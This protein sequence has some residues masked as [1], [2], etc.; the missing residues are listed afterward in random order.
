MVGGA[1]A[2][3]LVGIAIFLLIRRKQRTH[4]T[5]KDSEAPTSKVHLQNWA[6][7]LMQHIAC[8]VMYRLHSWMQHV[9]SGYHA[10]IMQTTWTIAAELQASDGTSMGGWASSKNAWQISGAGTSSGG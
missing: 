10:L 8:E 4:A 6:N 9:R 2:L 3:A 7:L 1:A 5:S